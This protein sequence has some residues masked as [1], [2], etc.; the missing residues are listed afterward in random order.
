M[1]PIISNYIN[2]FSR[3]KSKSTSDVLVINENN[4]EAHNNKY[5]SR[6]S[7]VTISTNGTN[8]KFNKIFPEPV[9]NP[10]SSQLHYVDFIE[11]NSI[12]CKNMSNELRKIYGLSINNIETS[13]KP[14]DTY[15][16]RNSNRIIPEYYLTGKNLEGQMFYFDYYVMIEDDIKNLRSL[17]EYQLKYIDSLDDEKKNNI[18]KLFNDSMI[19]MIQVNLNSNKYPS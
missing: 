10:E 12:K 13:W 18:I 14:P 4:L 1:I 2:Y 7:I 3:K 8:I 6:D 5:L 17:S 11:S 19:T 15:G 16:L 9:E